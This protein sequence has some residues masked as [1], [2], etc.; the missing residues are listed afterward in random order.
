[1]HSPADIGDNTQSLRAAYQSLCAKPRADGRGAIY[2]FA[3]PRTGAGTSYVARNI[4]QIAKAYQ[5]D[6]AQ[7]LLVDMDIQNNAQSTHFFAPETQGRLGAPEGPYDASFG[8]EPFWR[9]TP[10]MVNEQGH[11]ITD[12]HFMSLHIVSA[13]GIAFTHFHWEQ[14]R[15]GQHVHLQSARAYWHKLR[16]H[17][18]VIIVDT[19]ALDRTDVLSTICPEADAT[20]MV[21]GSEDMQAQSLADTN[22]LITDIG[23]SCAGVILNEK[24]TPVSSYGGAA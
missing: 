5:P 2:V 22:K 7:V 18:P 3:S 11:N 6:G 21:S 14:F 23:G 10:S 8:A 13:A 4:A 24:P 15:D 12:S 16:D 19:P 20:V 1:M 17:F 9:V